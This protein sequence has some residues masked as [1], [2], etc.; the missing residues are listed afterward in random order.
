MPSPAWR[1]S[2]KALVAF[3]APGSVRLRVLLHCN[4]PEYALI[5]PCL[6]CQT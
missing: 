5:R 4:N 1:D 3:R 6:R 2:A